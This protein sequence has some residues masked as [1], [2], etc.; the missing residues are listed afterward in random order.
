[1][2]PRRAIR[3]HGDVPLRLRGLLRRAPP[4]A[5]RCYW[6]LRGLAAAGL[7]GFHA[8]VIARRIERAL[9]GIGR[10]RFAQV[11]SN[12]GVRGDPLRPL[13]LRHPGWEGVFAEPVP[14]LFARLVRNYPSEPRLHFEQVAIA[15]RPGRRPVFAVSADAERAL[16]G[17][18]PSWYDQIASLDAEHL[19][20]HL[21]ERIRPFLVAHEVECIPLAQLLA[22]AGMEQ[23]DLL[24]L[25]AEGADYEILRQLELGPAAPA[26]VLFEHAHLP[27]ADR[28][29]ATGRLRAAGY[30]LSRHG[31]DTLALRPARS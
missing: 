5:P 20:A 23:I 13:A 14:E 12:D 28:R 16:R 7:A 18:L 1:V 10:V 24:H 22:R 6:A 29:A 21:G 19:V 8:R 30:R 9:R 26:V 25:D 3:Q 17:A 27:A 11:G 31:G 15:G 2:E 4:G